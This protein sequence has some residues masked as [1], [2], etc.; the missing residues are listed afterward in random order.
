MRGIP[1]PT[2]R[3][4]FTVMPLGPKEGRPPMPTSLRSPRRRSLAGRCGIPAEA[5]RIYVEVDT[6]V[7][8]TSP[9]ARGIRPVRLIWPDGR[10]WPIE[11]VYTTWEFGREIFGNLCIRYDVCMRRARKT[12]WWEHGEWFVAKNAGM[13]PRL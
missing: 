10:S 6:Q 5:D 11:S 3:Y 7:I 12:I 9:T 8:S 1:V 2:A 4:G 13:A